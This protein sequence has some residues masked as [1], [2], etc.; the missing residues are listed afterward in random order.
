[1]ERNPLVVVGVPRDGDGDPNAVLENWRRA[2]ETGLGC[3][4]VD[5]DQDDQGVTASVS[6]AGG[7]VYVNTV[8][9]EHRLQNY[10]TESGAERV[11]ATVNQFDRFY[12]CLLYT[13]PSPR[14]S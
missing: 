11:A 14:D 12:N 10:E 4:I 5:G 1:M 7:Y 2:T 9:P 13:S 8:A 3:V 6:K